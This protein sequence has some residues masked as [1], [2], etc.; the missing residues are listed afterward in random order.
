MKKKVMKDRIL[1][2]FLWVLSLLVLIPFAIVILGSFKT[3]AEAGAFTLNL[4]SEWVFSNYTE[5]IMEAKIFRALFNSLFIAA[6]SVSICVIVSS[7]GAFVLARKRTKAAEYLY[8]F[9]YTGMVAPVQTIPTIRLMQLMHIY[10][11]YT[12]VILLNAVFNIAFSVFL[13]TGFF[14]SIPR[15]IDE[16]ALI[17]G[18]SQLNMFFKVIFPIAKPTTMTVATLIFLGIWNDINVPLYFLNDSSKW[19]MPMTVY[20]FFGL[21][22]QSWNLVFANIVLIA[23]PVFIIYIIS[24]RYLVSGITAGAVKG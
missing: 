11:G 16:A 4:P 8:L 7:M 1:E 12:N 20:Q 17:D 5:V 3:Q 19:T 24:Q 6:L 22:Y 18:A 13:Y 21:H 14:K 2:V 10:G 15:E 23:L 9:I